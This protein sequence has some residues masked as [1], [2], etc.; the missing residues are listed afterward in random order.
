M[1]RPFLRTPVVVAAGVATLVA[2]GGGSI[3]DVG[4]WYQSLQF[5][6][7]KP[8]DWAFGPV[9]SVI[10]TL[11]TIVAIRC[12]DRAQTLG[13]KQRIIGLFAL[14][15]VLNLLWSVLFFSMHRPDWALWEVGPLW[16]SIALL[17]LGLRRLYQPST[18][19]LMPYLIWVAIAATLNAYIVF[20]NPPFGSS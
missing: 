20:N 13:D 15:Y 3:T 8:P 18:S 6:P 1:S 12:W 16:I 4:P 7:W 5:P 2:A 19:M 9:W 10:F 11:S 17:M 14:N